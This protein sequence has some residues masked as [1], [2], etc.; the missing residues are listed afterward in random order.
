MKKKGY[1]GDIALYICLIFLIGIAL[2]VIW[3]MLSNINTAIQAS[4]GFSSGSKSIV[5]NFSGRFTKIYDAFFVFMI[6][7]LFICIL[8][9]GFSIQSHPVFAMFALVMGIFL[10]IA[11]IYLANAYHNTMGSGELSSYASQFT[12]M[13]V[14][15]PKMPHIVLIFT[16][17][18]I[19]I[20]Y[21]K[22][23]SNSI[24]L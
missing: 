20:L 22:T 7:G 12:M 4:D 1:I 21:A 24:T 13:N 6:I 16:I 3:Y 23:R 14:I 19:V 11:S 5:S 9:F 2:V 17:V 8:I 18:F 10:T 15:M